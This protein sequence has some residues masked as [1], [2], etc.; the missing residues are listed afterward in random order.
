MRLQIVGLSEAAAESKNGR[1]QDD[2]EKVDAASIPF[3]ALAAEP[4]DL[5]D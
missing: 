4:S 2:L 5:E 1:G 3:L